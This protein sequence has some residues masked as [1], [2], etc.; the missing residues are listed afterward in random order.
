MQKTKVY[1]TTVNM[2]IYHYGNSILGENLLVDNVRIM[3]NRH[4]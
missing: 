4:Q 1:Y 2:S 3:K